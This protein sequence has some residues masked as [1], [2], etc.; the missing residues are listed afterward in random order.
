MPEISPMDYAFLAL[1]SVENPKHVGPVQILRPPK[2]APADYVSRFVDN[3]RQRQPQ[4]PFNYKLKLIVPNPLGKLP[5]LFGLLP[6]LS[7]A[8]FVM[9]QWRVVESVNME[10]HVFH[11]VLPKPGTKGQLTRKLQELHQP[12]LNRKRPMWECHVIEGYEGGQRF[13]VYTKIHHSLADGGLLAARLITNTATV[14]DFE[15]GMVF[16]ES[17]GKA[18]A[19]KEHSENLLDDVSNMTK[20]MINMSNLAGNMYM[21]VLRSGVGALLQTDSNE[22]GRAKHFSAPVTML[23]KQPDA[24][25]SLAF[26]GMPLARVK[27][28][29]K[30]TGATINDIL[31]T[32]LDMGVRQYLADFNEEPKQRMVALMPLS[33][34]DK[35]D[36]VQ[37]N[38]LSMA[39]ILLGSVHAS[40]LERLSDIGKETVKVKDERNLSPEMALAKTFVLSGLAQ[41]GEGLNLSGTIAPL[42]NFVFSNVPGSQEIRYQFDALIEE[43][44]PISCLAPG[45]YL[46]VTVYSYA[47]FVYFQ[48]IALEK[49]APNLRGLMGHVLNAVELIE[50]EVFGKAIS[51]SAVKVSV[52]E[53][54]DPPAIPAE[55]SLKSVASPKKV[56]KTFAK[57]KTA[58][59]VSSPKKG[60]K[61]SAKTRA[62][63][64]PVASSKKT[65]KA[66][67]KT[68][69]VKNAVSPK[70]V[71]KASIKAPVVKDSE[72][73]PAKS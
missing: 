4:T 29:S 18:A 65:I 8:D 27:N 59:N 33:L 61:V 3:M 10:E 44:Y 22:K 15:S 34:R 48:L 41:L 37:G 52:T 66:S 54:V 50:H 67:A 30:A 16:W 13:A 43:I 32:L 1:E 72:A 36:S 70:K 38:C 40:P 55:T 17:P 19:A 5:K 69:P 49:S 24:G 62:A 9:P 42:G 12:L 57:K 35:V 51:K 25:R 28:L 21:S 46:N 20:S 45:T 23:D 71:V 56:V 58:K 2:G 7:T 53:A 14:P 47:G 31:L 6:G 64:K 39:T 60:V 63:K 73:V 26:G 68:K 11:H